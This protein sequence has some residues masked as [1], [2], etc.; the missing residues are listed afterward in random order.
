MYVIEPANEDKNK[1]HVNNINH[2]KDQSDEHHD[3]PY[4]TINNSIIN[5]NSKNSNTT[6]NANAMSSSP[7]L[8]A[9]QTGSIKNSVQQG[10]LRYINI[11]KRKISPQK[12]Y[13]TEKK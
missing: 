2:L 3:N 8:L 13:N 10:I 11:N 9:K 7:Q 12:A 4:H 5:I 1:K 6:Q